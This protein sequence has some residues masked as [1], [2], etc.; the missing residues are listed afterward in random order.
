MNRPY[1]QTPGLAARLAAW[2]A[3]LSTDRTLPFA[4]LGIVDDLK[5]AAQ[6]LT[7]REY[8]DWLRVHGDPA[9]IEFVDDLL[10]DADT[11][12]A[13]QDAADRAQAS[14]KD[15]GA[16]PVAVI[17]EIDD[18]ATRAQTENAALRSVLIDIGALVDDDEETDIADLLRALLS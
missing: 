6:I 7:T 14:S 12:D 10:R 5:M 3:R 16:D 9:H 11:L 8:L 17:E 13:V 1:G 18:A 4:G 2:A 15:G